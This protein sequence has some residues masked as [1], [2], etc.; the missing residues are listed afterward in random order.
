MQQPL[1]QFASQHGYTKAA[2]LL[3][4]TQGGI[5]HAIKAQ[6]EIFVID[7]GDGTYE[8]KELKPFPS[9]P[10]AMKNRK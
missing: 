4:L 10:Q 9:S 5:S 2:Q 7:K 1:E 3:C 6:R 8:A